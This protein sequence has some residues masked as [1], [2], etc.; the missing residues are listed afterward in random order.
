VSRFWVYIALLALV[1]VGTKVLGWEGRQVL[2]TAIFLGFI[3]GTLLFW[4]FRLAFALLGI[5]A[6]L[7]TNVLD[8]PHLIEFAS[9]DI[10]LFLIGMMIVVGFLEE[11]RFFE[12]IVEKALALLPGRAKVLIASMMA[13]AALSAALVDEV[14]SILFMS[15]ITLQVTRRFR[16]EPVP[17]I[18]LIVFA[19]NIGSS[20]TVVGNPIG[21]MIALRGNLTF[22]DFLRWATPI[23][24][25]GLLL[26]IP[27]SFWY[28][29][30]DLGH[31][32]R[33]LLS[34]ADEVV[35]IE[36][37]SRRDFLL[38]LPLFLGTIAGLVFH[39]Q[40]ESLLGLEKNTMLIG[41]AAFFAGI[42]LFLE[43][44]RARELVEQRVDWW[45]LTFFML[46]FAS[47][48][49]L[50]YVGVTRQIAEGFISLTSGREGLLLSA[51]TWGSGLLSAFMDNVLAVAT[52]IPVVN[53]LQEIG[54]F[55]EPLWWGLLFGGTF[56]G[57]V[58]MIGSTA[59]IVA[60]GILERDEGIHISFLRW[61]KPGLLVGIPTLLL[62]HLLLYL[63][64]SLMR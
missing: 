25:A 8:L 23:A 22:V 12:V 32:D 7:A 41:V 3:L 36:K 60:L 56:L 47:A 54:A 45:T 17:F 42:A 38:S 62:A 19:T 29:S 53:D 27:L 28:F 44:D 21:V 50:R 13:M 31:L 16:I 48:G 37:I 52:L 18:I 6:L 59:N 51:M 49:T 4:K 58:T 9:L 30:K 5:V 61:L 11:R 64:L 20:A 15:A 26:A 39:H 1:T 40:L 63:Q 55:V 34:K 35:K 57:N 2:A 14:T 33:V 43:R 24:V 10:I 46:L